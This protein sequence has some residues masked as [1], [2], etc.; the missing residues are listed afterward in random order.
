M[1][2]V[3]FETLDQFSTSSFEI[4]EFSPF[5][6]IL[7]DLFDVSYAFYDC[8]WVIYTVDTLF[9]LILSQILSWNMLEMLNKFNKIW[10][11]ELNL[12]ISKDKELDWSK[13]SK[14][15][16]SKIYWKLRDKKHI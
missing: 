12:C 11:K 8:I 5:N 3:H 14:W 6:Q 9:A 13:T 7:L 15:T 2:L 10:L 16:N 1:E 4:C